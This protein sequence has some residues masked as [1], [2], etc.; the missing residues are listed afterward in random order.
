MM[1]SP[2]QMPIPLIE[3]SEATMAASSHE[4]S[5][6]SSGTEPL[7]SGHLEARFRSLTEMS[8]DFYWESDAEH[9]LTQGGRR[10]GGHALPVEPLEQEVRCQRDHQQEDQRLHAMRR[11]QEHR[12]YCQRRLELAI[13]PFRVAPVDFRKWH[14]E[15]LRRAQYN[16]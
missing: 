2:A 14:A 16:L 8:S 1:S 5:M 4:S 12:M 13:G 6:A 9:R 15:S 3:V 11:F 10:V 7:E